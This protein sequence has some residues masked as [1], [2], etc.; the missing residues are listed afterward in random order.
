MIAGFKTS[1]TQQQA[2]QSIELVQEKI[3]KSETGVTA[4]QQ[5][6]DQAQQAYFNCDYDEAYELSQRALR[7]LPITLPG[8]R[9]WIFLLIVAI[10]VGTYYYYKNYYKKKKS[11]MKIIKRKF[12]T[13]QK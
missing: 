4:A 2:L 10:L 12:K 1:A 8:L 11:I 9:M 3:E 13:A 7:L 5:L 6:L